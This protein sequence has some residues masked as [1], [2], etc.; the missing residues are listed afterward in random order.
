MRYL[1]SFVIIMVAAGVNAQVVFQ[2]NFEGKEVGVDLTNDGYVL[3]KG[4]TYTGTVTVTVAES[5][6]NKFARMVADVSAGANMQIAKTI[7]V[8]PGK[9]YVYSVESKGPFKRQLRVYSTSDVLLAS[10]PDYK[11]S[12]PEEETTW[13]KMDLSFVPGDGIT[14][15]KICFFHY[16][17]GTIDIDNYLVESVQR[18]T[19]FYVSS[20]LGDDANDG[21]E[22]SPWKSLDKISSTGLFP[23]DSVLFKRGDTFN[24]HF[25]VNGS[26]TKEEPI[27]VSSYGEG[28]KPVISGQVGAENG[29]DYQ[30]AILVE[31]QDN[32]IFDGIEV[33]N[34][35]LVARTGVV[36]TDAYGIYVRN[37]GTSPMKNL[38]FRNM[39]F[40]NVFAA[41]PMLNPEDF[42]KIQVAALSFYSTKNTVAGSEKNISEILVEDCYFGNNQRF[43]IQFKHSGGNVGIG[44]DSINRNMNIIIRRNEF[45]YNG[46]T[47][48]LP[49][50][51]YNCLIEDNIFDH[52][53]ASTDPRMPGRGSSIWNYNAINTIMQYNTCLS[54]RGYLDSY[55]IH[56]D[57]HNKNTFVQYNYMDDCIGGFVE[58]LADNVNAVYRFNVSLNSGF[59]YTEGVS[60][61]KAGSSTIY[62]YSDRWTEPNQAGLQLCDGVYVY[63]NTVVINKEFTTT[64]SVDAK[65]MFIYNNIF[66][67]T[68]GATMGHLQ[69]TVN[70]NDTPFALK[71]N[72]YQGNVNPDWVS[73]DTAPE[74]GDPLFAGTGQNEDVFKLQDG[75]PAI[76]K[77]TAITGPIVKNA[78]YGVFKDIAPYPAVDLYGNPIDLSTGTPNIGACNYKG[79]VGTS[80]PDLKGK[81]SSWLVYPNLSQSRIHFIYNGTLTEPVTVSLNNLNG[82]LIQLD[83]VTVDK[84]NAAFDLHLKSAIANGIYV[85]NIRSGELAESRK[86]VLVN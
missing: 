69:F 80:S 4:D 8:V 55:G 63:N 46:G 72:L 62:I 49:N 17:S 59:R 84:G 41:E 1:V 33:Q 9:S 85:L 44:N 5:G 28:E 14:Q 18:Q 77:G 25:V 21:T 50:A 23:G 22:T 54:T 35:R 13:K 11:P 65:N 24:G 16:W 73:M 40:K 32:L 68:N 27:L 48:V 43:G 74:N 36:N 3:T 37:S 60:T 38:V 15:V 79:S 71:N 29:G 56:I 66:S 52:P 45:Y 42:D 67:S 2:E 47:G 58:I 81:E 39:S 10:S 51:T 19:A 53:G 75:S 83:H 26:G 7:T 61:W 78:G 30:E 76:N 31:N 34:E 6:G 20:S 70:A 12:I 86:I 57:K 64:F 82:Q